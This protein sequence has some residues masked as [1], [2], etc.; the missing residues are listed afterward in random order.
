MMSGI[1][2]AAASVVTNVHAEAEADE[3]RRQVQ[4][5]PPRQQQRLAADD[6]LQLAVR[7]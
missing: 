4:Q 5:M 1:N 6:A 3:H 7:R 2:G